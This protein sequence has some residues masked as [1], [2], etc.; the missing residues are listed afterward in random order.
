MAKPVFAGF[1][2]F[3]SG[4]QLTGNAARTYRWH[5]AYAVLDSAAGGILLNA[6]L[7][8]IKKFQAANWHL[9]LREL[10]A[11]LGMILTLYLGSRMANR[12]KM[13]YIII[14]GVTAGICSLLMATAT[15]SAFW[16][17][18]LLGIG[19]LFE[20]TTRPAIAAVLRANYP[21]E[22][23]GHATGEA[24]KWSSLCFLLSSVASA[25]I[26][27]FASQY[28]EAAD[29]MTLTGA[30]HHGLWWLTEHMASLLMVLAGLLSLA[31]FACFRQIHVDETWE[32]LQGASR[33]D[34]AQS[35]RETLVIL[36]HDH[37]YRRYLAGC[38]LDGFFQ[39]L[40]FPLI[41]I[42]L[43]QDL[44]FGYVGCNAL[45][46]AIPALAAFATTGWLGRLFDR[47]NPW[48]AWGGV[49]CLWGLDAILLAATPWLAQAFPPA[50]LLVPILGRLARGSV[51]GGW[52]ILWWQI[53]VTFFAPVGGAT[54]RYMGIMVFLNGLIRFS[55]SAAG[56]VLTAL[57]VSPQ[58][59][60]ILGGA[61]VMLSGCYSF[62]HA[63]W[64]RRHR[65]PATIADFEQR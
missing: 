1:L 33:P 49:R 35:L 20:V 52:W 62:Y 24:R 53:G 41:W 55:A 36:T 7:I 3:L 30:V 8:A 51:Q 44:G 15:G 21:V 23:R 26:L 16:F 13:P 6:P 50:L 43:S 38:F 32:Q 10:C 37:R 58:T 59:L 63:A 60:L 28:V 39:M 64:D 45:M 12:P 47:T 65:V 14:P 54:S 5:V 19:A 46:H 57:A 42:F 22:H 29:S 11:G 34:I 27:H 9:P 48:I 56:M 25:V 4:P 61:G 17:L 2:A 18:T 40:Y 31:S